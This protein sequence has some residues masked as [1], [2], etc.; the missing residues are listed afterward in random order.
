MGIIFISIDDNEMH[1]LK[2]ICDEVF[3]EEN[4]ID[5]IIWKKK[6]GGGAKEKY[7]V[8]VHE[9]ILIYCRNKFHLPEILVAFDEEIYCFYR[10]KDE[11]FEVMGYYRTLILW[12]QLKALIYE[13]I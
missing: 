7:L 6:Y 1:N 4:F 10:F 2:K 11:K 8:S 9:Y 12:K 3:G 5:T 13:K